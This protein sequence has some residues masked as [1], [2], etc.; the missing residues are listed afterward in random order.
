MDSIAA[1]WGEISSLSKCVCVCV[2]IRFDFTAARSLSVPYG[3]DVNAQTLVDILF[4]VFQKFSF[5]LSY[6]SRMKPLFCP[7][8]E[9]IHAS[10]SRQ[11]CA[12]SA[13]NACTGE[14]LKITQPRDSDALLMEG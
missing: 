12:M 9:R 1:I 2:W 7:Y 13:D 14:Y 3:P 6:H 8:L 4:P 10:D 5:N 11:L